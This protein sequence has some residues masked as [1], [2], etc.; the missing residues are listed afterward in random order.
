MYR[1]RTISAIVLFIVVLLNLRI[2]NAPNVYTLYN[3]NYME[4]HEK[5]TFFSLCRVCV[6]WIM[7]FCILFRFC[8]VCH[9]QLHI[10]TS[11]P[12]ELAILLNRFA[13]LRLFF[14]VLLLLLHLC[15]LDLHCVVNRSALNTKKYSEW[16]K[17]CCGYLNKCNNNNDGSIIILKYVCN[18]RCNYYF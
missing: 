6:I 2:R 13:Y 10:Y 17:N 12:V 9:F 4:A 8:F 5:K 7:E 11:V 16:K 1:H 14:P 15:K 3:S 18:T